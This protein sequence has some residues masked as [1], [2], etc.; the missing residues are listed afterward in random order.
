MSRNLLAIVLLSSSLA[1]SAC[2]NCSNKCVGP[3]LQIFVAAEMGEVELCTTNG[4][5]NRQGFGSPSRLTVGRSFT[6]L[7]DVVDGNIDVTIS[8]F[9]YSGEKFTTE[10]FEVKAPQQTCSCI[11]PIDLFVDRVGIH[12]VHSA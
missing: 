9:N 12:R 6:Y 4:E 7:P 11:A 3:R 10:K 8:G 2:T 5:C 1:A